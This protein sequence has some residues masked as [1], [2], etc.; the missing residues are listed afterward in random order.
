MKFTPLAAV[1]A[2]FAALCAFM[3]APASAQGNTAYAVSGVYVDETAANGA[4]AQQAAFASAERI[5]F[6]RLA[7]RLTVGDSPVPTPDQAT[8]DRMTLS[9]DI[10]E[11][12]RSG[13][14]YIGR[15]TVRFDA[16]QVRQI[17]QAQNL[18]V[19]DARTAPT[20]VVPVA[21]DGTSDDAV[22]AWR[23]VWTNGGFQ[24]ELAPLT[25]APDTLQGA[26]D[27]QNA[28]PFAQSAAAA[29]AL[30]ATLR[31]QGST[32]SAALVQVSASGNQDRG[33]VSAQINGS[34]P[35]ALR[36]ALASLAQQASDI[37]QNEWKSHASS[38]GGATQTRVS[39]SALYSDEHQWQ[40]IKDALGA[41]SATLI[42]QIRIEAVGRDGALV[43]FQFVG[44]RAQLATELARRGVLLQDTQMGP[45]LRV[46]PQQ[47]APAVQGVQ[48]AQTPQ[49]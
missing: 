4:A 11:E 3:A 21:V 9:T 30:Y 16:A 43:S 5:G 7:R 48:P 37:V 29:S 17:L 15:L 27:W 40:T 49:H 39:A 1:F 6:E 10:E 19:V 12:H 18:S 45:V 46:T 47:A 20:L 35:A 24:Q 42:S 25:A 26:P 13:T 31:V 23:D 36:A 34:D 38:A 22:A 41:A 32:A 44:D 14:R 2:V 8:L 28:A 33:T